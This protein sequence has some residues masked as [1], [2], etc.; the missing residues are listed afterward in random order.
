M[1]TTTIGNHGEQI[2]AEAMIRQ[3]YEIIDRNW[4]TKWAEIDIVAQKDGIMHFA[5]VKFR[6][7]TNQGDGFDYITDQKLMQMQRAA[8]LWVSMRHW[9]GEY[10]L[11]GVSV[12]GQ[13]NAVDIREIV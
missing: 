12:D 2:A 9:S 13:G 11:L 10:V 3:G 8:E 7:S 6:S 4:K 5:E 1:L